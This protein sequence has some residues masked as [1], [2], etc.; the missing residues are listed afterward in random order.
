MATY[1]MKFMYDWGSGVCLWCTNH[2]AKT[3]FIDYPILTSKLPVSEKLK[4]ELNHLIEL[5]D[6]AL[7]WNEPNGDLLWNDKQI[8]EFLK[9]TQNAY[10]RLCNELG[11]DYEIELIEVI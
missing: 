10:N 5:H 8:D 3:K 2:T 9:A 7:N 1:K 4:D 11:S 6:T